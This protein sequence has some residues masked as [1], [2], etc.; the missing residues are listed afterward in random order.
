VFKHP[1]KRTIV[2]DMAAV[3]LNKKNTVR[4]L[5]GSPFLALALVPLTGCDAG[6]TTFEGVWLLVVV[7]LCAA[8]TPRIEPEVAQ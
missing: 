7:L 2:S 6:A 3:G 4:R 1:Q 5:T 8:L